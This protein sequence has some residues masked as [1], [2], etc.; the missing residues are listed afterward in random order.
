MADFELTFQL[1]AYL[2]AANLLLKTIAV[3]GC[4]VTLSPWVHV[5]YKPLCFL[6]LGLGLV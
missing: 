1:V 3:C 2:L 4:L 5:H 6:N